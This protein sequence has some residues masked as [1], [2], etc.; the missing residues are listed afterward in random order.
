MNTAVAQT[1]KPFQQELRY[2]LPGWMVES[3]RQPSGADSEL[4]S[5]GH[6]CRS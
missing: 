4:C 1:R 2:Y 5:R 3:E 6:H